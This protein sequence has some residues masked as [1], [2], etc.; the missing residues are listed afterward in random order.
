M[1]NTGGT[2]DNAKKDIS[3]SERVPM[4]LTLRANMLMTLFLPHAHFSSYATCMRCGL[5]VCPLIGATR[6]QK[7]CRFSITDNV[8]SC[9]RD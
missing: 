8:F 9:G 4:V 2:W 5:D 7:N 3:T 6:T 1:S